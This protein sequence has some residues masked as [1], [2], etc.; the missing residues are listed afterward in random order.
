M[1]NK[2][3]G[4]TLNKQLNNSFHVVHINRESPLSKRGEKKMGL[5]WERRMENDDK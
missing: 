2:G 3:K 1:N 4:M 5:D